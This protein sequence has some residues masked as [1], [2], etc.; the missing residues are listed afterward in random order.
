MG[1]DTEIMS[2]YTLPTGI[3]TE[4]ITFT[5]S[6]TG[7]HYPLILVMSFSGYTAHK[8]KMYGFGPTT[9]LSDGLEIVDGNG[10]LKRLELVFDPSSTGWVMEVNG[11]PLNAS[12]ATEFDVSRGT[13]LESLSIEITSPSGKTSGDPKIKVIRP[14][15]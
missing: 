13:G 5:P 2:R 8:L 10:A 9:P 11:S 4:T 3:T 15:S 12:T 7:E 1:Q 14:T 6:N